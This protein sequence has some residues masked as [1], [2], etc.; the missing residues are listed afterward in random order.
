MKKLLMLCIGLVSSSFIL[1]Q[2]ITDAVRYSMDEIQGTARFK[3]MSGAFGALGG[4]MSSVNINPAGSAIFNNSHASVSL[5]LYNKSNDINY[6]GGINSSSDLNVDLNQ[7]GAVFVFDN[8]NSNSLWKKF[9]LS[10]AY[11]SSGNFDDDWVANGTNPNNSIGDY[12][13]LN[14]QGLRLDEISALPGE[15][16]SQAYSEIGSLFGFQNQQAFLG[17]EGYII[18]PLEDT[19]ENT[20]Y[21]SN[22]NGGDYNQRFAY[23]STGYNGKLAFN[24]ATSYNDKFYF[25][26]NLNSHFINYERSTFLNE[27]NS[28]VSSTVTNVNFENNLLTTGTGFSLQLGGIAKITEELRVGLSYNSPTWYRVSDETSQYLSTNRIEDG[29]NINQVINPNV[30]NVYEEYKLQ[31]PAKI[32]GSLAY[33]FGKRGL[34]SL[35]YSMK[36]YSNTKFKPTSDAYFSAINNDINDRLTSA[37]TIRLGG[38]YRYKQ[39]SFRGG[40]RFEESPYKDTDFYGDLTGYSLGIGY[41]FGSI[42]LDL[43][44]SQATRDTNYQ[45]YNVGLTDAASIETNYT[46]FVVTLGFN[47]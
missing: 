36:D 1:A 19:D 37:A 39:I 15:S 35:D 13:R 27:R 20:N 21:T 16:I 17:Y 33:V 28:N 29:Q 4:D 5:G 32:T 46:D 25:G 10:V 44:F 40:Y 47:L 45:L 7:L 2:D 14:A 11:D 8:M 41:N 38:E 24:F 31:T 6:F 30:I 26:L 34:L 42:N 23:A 3:A 9:S 12:F 22:I 18:N 43:A